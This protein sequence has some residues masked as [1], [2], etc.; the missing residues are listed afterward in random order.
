VNLLHR[1]ETLAARAAL[2]GLRRMSPER[3]S[4]LGGAVTRALGPWL[5]VSRVAL[6]NLA[7]AMPELDAAARRRVLR[8]VWENL[9]RTVAEFPHLSC[10]VVNAPQGPGVELVGEPIL[11]ELVARGG[12]VIFF[13][14]HFGNWEV[15]PPVAAK[16]GCGFASMYRAAANPAIDR[17]ISDLRAEAVGGEVKLFPKGAA[18]ARAAMGQ[19]ARGGNLALLVDQKLNDG[20]EARLFGMRAMTA[21]AVAAFALRYRCPVIGAYV[22]RTGPMRFRVVVEAP[23][24]LPA[25][26]DRQAD[27]A[28]VT[29]MVNDRMEA[30]IRATPEAWLWLHRR[31]PKDVVRTG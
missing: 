17:I 26:G 13:S 31:W 3:A 8:G 14:A 12:P 21:P 2:A 10:L 6:A 23:L 24:A 20:I 16:F 27:I 7:A 15:L 18:G 29:Q 22:L 30:W 11:H 1:L 19:L 4:N 9:G 25:S 5:P 28:A